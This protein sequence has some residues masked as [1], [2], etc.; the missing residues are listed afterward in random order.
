MMAENYCFIRPLLIVENLIRSGQFGEIYYAESDY[1][2][3]FQ[4]YKCRG[5][6][7]KR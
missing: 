5:F 2:K 6:N 3:D 7:V 1:L 4:E